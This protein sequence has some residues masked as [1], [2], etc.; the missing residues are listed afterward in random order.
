MTARQNKLKLMD[1]GKSMKD[2]ADEL[3]DK[4]PGPTDKS[5]Q[6]MVWNMIYKRGYYP[7]YA[8]YLNETYG[9]RFAKPESVRQILRQAA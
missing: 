6:T 7:R 1:I 9:F 8:N 5:M 2:L 3:R 4:F